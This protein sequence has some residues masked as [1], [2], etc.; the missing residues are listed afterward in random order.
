[1]AYIQLVFVLCSCILFNSKAYPNGLNIP[2]FGG[3]DAPPASKHGP[4]SGSLLTAGTIIKVDGTV[5]T[6]TTKPIRIRA[7]SQV[8]INVSNPKTAGIFFRLANVDVKRS[9]DT[10]FKPIDF[11]NLQY[12][13]ACVAPFTGIVQTNSR[14]KPNVETT[15]D[16]TGF[17]GQFVLSISIV[18]EVTEWYYS[19]F[20]LIIDPNVTARPVS[21]TN[22][23]RSP[24]TLKPIRKPTNLP[25]SPPVKPKSTPMKRPSKPVAKPLP[26]KPKPN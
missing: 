11:T 1:M 10:A 4:V 14:I 13:A 18:F 2:C 22:A 6:T 23:P 25:R 7:S 8:R 3:E 26:R 15:F 5:V 16:T 17:T 9:I 12:A 21:P 19:S 24:P 20:R